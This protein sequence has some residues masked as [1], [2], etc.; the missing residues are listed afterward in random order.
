MLNQIDD[1]ENLSFKVV[2]REHCRRFRLISRYEKS[3]RDNAGLVV[4]ALVNDVKRSSVFFK[5]KNLAP[6]TA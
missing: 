3:I 2:P 5:Y 6:S 1:N 4:S